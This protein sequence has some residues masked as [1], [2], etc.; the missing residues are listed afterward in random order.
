MVG[1]ISLVALWGAFSGVVK[2]VVQL[3]SIVIGYLLARPIATF[4]GPHM[5]KAFHVPQVVGIVAATFFAFI[6]VVI[7]VRILGTPLLRKLLAGK[8]PEDHQLD[9]FLGL[10]FGAL[11]A[12]AFVYVVLSCLTFVEDN[13]S[14]AGKRLGLTPK[15]SAFF[16]LAR[17]HNLITLTHF[18][19]LDDLVQIVNASGD[20]QKLARLERSP[21]YQ[22]LRKDPRF[23]AAVS[24]QN[25]RK[26]FEHGDASALL[27]SN[28]ILELVQDRSMS[29]ELQNAAAA[30]R[31]ER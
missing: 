9:R 12:S 31:G 7:S 19:A 3:A 25:L 11:K 17:K 15:D 16:E 26:A 4:L 5:A 28:A 29:D 2:Q 13:V 1:L 24:E 22:A 18:S 20:P 30:S 27:R 10:L 6:L 23:R 14:V 21:A 8:T